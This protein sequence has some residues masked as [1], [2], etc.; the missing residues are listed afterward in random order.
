MD[1]TSGSLEKLPIYARL[2][3][4]EVWRWRD[5]LLTIF[6]AASD[7]GYR[8]SAHSRAIPDLEADRI[9]RWLE[10]SRRMPPILWRRQVAGWARGE[11]A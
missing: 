8:Q 7:G 6:V 10:E 4:P 11:G 9:G 1:V 3:V 5:G 2:G